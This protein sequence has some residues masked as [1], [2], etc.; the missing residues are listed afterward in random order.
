M[1]FIIKGFQAIVFIFIVVSTMFRPICPPTFIRCLLSKFLKQRLVIIIKGFWTIVFIFIVISTSWYKFNLG[2]I[3]ALIF[4]LL[5]APSWNELGF[6]L[7]SL[8]SW[9]L[10]KNVRWF[11]ILA[12]FWFSFSNCFHWYIVSGPSRLDINCLNFWNEAWW[13]S[14]L[15]FFRL[16]S[17]SLFPLSNGNNNK[18]EDNSL[19]TLND[20]N[21]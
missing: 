4:L 19:K 20:E 3:P 14:S 18:D 15:S 11:V 6:L 13:F 21:A 16:L 8:V 9:H 12:N 1:I 2:L 7:L 5:S 17:S 10:H